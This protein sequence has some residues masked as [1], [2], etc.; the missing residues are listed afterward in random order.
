MSNTLLSYLP[1]NFTPHAITI[2]TSDVV[3]RQFRPFILTKLREQ[4]STVIRRLLDIFKEKKFNIEELITI[5]RFDDAEKNTIFST[6]Y[7]FNTII[8]ESQLFQNVA[9]YCKS[10]YDYQVLIILVKA[11][12]CQE[13]IKELNDFTKMLQNSILAEIDLISEH[14]ELLHPDDLMPGT[15]KFIIEYVGGKCTMGTKEMIQNVVEQSVRLRKG[16]LIF[17][18]FDIGSFVLVYQISEVVKKYLL[19]YRFT[20]QDLMFLEGNCITNLIV[21]DTEIMKLNKVIMRVT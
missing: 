2:A 11:S 15:Y 16:V 6:D 5:L 18:G 17:R 12:R 7:V 19:E 14:G 1:Y 21:D 4:Y 9:L 10:F 13:A 3:V 8:T 20:K